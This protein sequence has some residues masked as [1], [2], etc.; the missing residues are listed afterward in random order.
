MF[1]NSFPETVLVRTIRYVDIL[2]QTGA[3]VPES[4]Q[5]ITLWNYMHII[6]LNFISWQT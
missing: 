6:E 1:W 4:L 2:L 3:F 5:T